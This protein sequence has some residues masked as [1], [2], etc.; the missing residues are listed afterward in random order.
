MQSGKAAMQAALAL[1]RPAR[2]PCAPHW[3]G[4][5]KYEALGLDVRLAPWQD[6]A[7]LA[8]VYAGFYERF[9]P[10][11][12]HL[13]IGTPRYFRDAEVSEPEGLGGDAV[14]RIDPHFRGLKKLDRYFASE[15][16]ADER[17]VDF[18]DYL[19]GSRAER[20][21]VDLGSRRSVEEY[22]RRYL[23]MEAALIRELGYADHVVALAARFGQEA[24]IAVHL[25]STVCELFDPITGWAGFERGLIALRE[26]P[27]GM[28][29]LLELGYELQL[30]W[31]RAYAQAGA[32]AFVISESYISPDIAG[33]R[34]YPD[35][36]KG[37]HREYFAEIARMGLAPILD[38][39]G[40][41]LPLL[42]DFAQIGAAA[43]MVEE[44]KKT[45]TLDIRE[46]RE[47]LDGRICLF[48]NLDSLGLLREGS[49]EEVRAEV[50]RQAEGAG[51][52]FVVANGSPLALGTPEANVRA[53]SEAAQGL[54][55]RSRADE[56]GGKR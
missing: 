40:D 9:R 6:G 46:I 43:L 23:A 53:L 11:W 13:H 8:P 54:P 45:F 49:P 42:E 39:W 56:A 41:A 44:S 16:G 10:D 3:W 19:L 35:F 4:S 38:F 27:E 31:A 32:H 20:P 5:Y 37:I 22:A 15:S 34:V 12:L 30:E 1:G 50:R 7:A 52:G 36:L 51:G 17:I 14:L 25:P 21:R 28:R 26:Q 18:P 55:A 24:L 47:R 48:G 29:R 2:V 33:P